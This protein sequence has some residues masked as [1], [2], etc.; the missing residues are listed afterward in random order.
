MT[1]LTTTQQLALATRKTETT[2][3]T[4]AQAKSWELPVCQRPLRVTKKIMEVAENIRE[5]GCIDGVITL[6]R[7][8]GSTALYLVDGQHRR[9]GFLLSDVESAVCDIRIVTY[10]SM[11]ELA[12]AFIKENSSLV[13]MR[14]DDIMRAHEVTTPAISMVRSACPFVGYDSIRRGTTAS[15]VLSMSVVVRCWFGSENE[16]PTGTQSGKSSAVLA[17]MLTLSDASNLIEFLNIAHQAWG[18]EP[19]YYRLWGA[20]NLSLCMWLWRRLVVDTDRSGVRR[21]AR[22]NATEFKNCLMAL[23]ADQNYLSWLVGRNSTDRDRS[24]CY[25]R[26]RTVISA[27]LSHENGGKRVNLPSPAWWSGSRFRG[28]GA[29]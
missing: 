16:T 11:K 24:P 19:E 4:P 3:I 5:T 7:L 25:T 21:Y 20:I 8:L 13:K 18:R 6:G 22:L 12:N 15:H 2:I 23:S 10:G 28:S 27:R 26:L 1:A 29:E 9:H 17:E 14:P